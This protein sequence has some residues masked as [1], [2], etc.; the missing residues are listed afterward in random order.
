MTTL[1]VHVYE[2]IGEKEV[3]LDCGVFVNYVMVQ[4]HAMLE[5]LSFSTSMEHSGIGLKGQRRVCV[6]VYVVGVKE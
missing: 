1:A 2:V 6:D 5:A 4:S 3:I